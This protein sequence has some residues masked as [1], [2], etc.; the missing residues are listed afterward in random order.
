MVW[1]VA[2][3]LDGYQCPCT[4]IHAGWSDGLGVTLTENRAT[5]CLRFGDP[6]CRLLMR[7]RCHLKRRHERERTECRRASPIVET[8]L[9]GL[10][11]N[12]E[13]HTCRSLQVGCVLGDGR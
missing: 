1:Y 5:G 10:W 11:Q 6:E 3:S 12:I 8:L 9:N 2:G 7:V 13:V 4:E